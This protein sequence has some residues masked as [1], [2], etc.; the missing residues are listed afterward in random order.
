MSVR[1]CGFMVEPK[2]ST[3]TWRDSPKLGDPAGLVEQEARQQ[4]DGPGLPE[5]VP[6]QLD[7]LDGRTS[8][9]VDV[10]SDVESPCI[11]RW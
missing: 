11:V 4:V 5:A 9:P 8:D 2:I 1:A 3:T 10:A 6:T 7:R